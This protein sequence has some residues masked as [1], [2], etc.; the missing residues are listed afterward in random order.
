M[1]FEVGKGFL[2]VLL[3]VTKNPFLIT[4]AP[5]IPEEQGRAVAQTACS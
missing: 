5:A 3:V 2:G 1:G 4:I